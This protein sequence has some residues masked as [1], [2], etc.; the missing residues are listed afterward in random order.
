MK[1]ST[2]HK[3]LCLLRP[4]YCDVLTGIDFVAKRMPWLLPPRF[5]LGRNSLSLENLNLKVMKEKIGRI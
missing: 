1:L 4:D 3:K 2:N 5:H